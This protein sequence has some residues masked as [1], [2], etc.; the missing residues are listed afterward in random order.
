MSRKVDTV[1]LHQ[2]YQ[3]SLQYWPPHYLPYLKASKT[4]IQG[5]Y[6]IEVACLLSQLKIGVTSQAAAIAHYLQ[7]DPSTLDMSGIDPAQLNDMNF[8]LDKITLLDSLSLL[9]D[10]QARS[11]ETLRKMLLAMAQDIRAVVIIL[12]E[13]VVTMRHLK[14]VSEAEQKSIAKATIAIHAPLANRLGLARLKWELEDLSLRYAEPESYQKIARILD[15]KRD[16]REQYIVDVINEIKELLAKHNIKAEVSGRVKHLYSI[17]KKMENKGRSF[18]ELFDV[19]AVRILVNDVGDCYTALGLI[20]EKWSPIPKEFD[21]YIANPKLNGYQSLHTAVIGPKDKTLEV[22]IRTTAMHDYA[23]LGV[24]AHWRYKEGNKA[25]N[26]QNTLNWLRQILDDKTGHSEDNLSE[27][28]AANAN[29]TDKND[30][31]NDVL[32]QFRAEV[33]SDH[34]YV[35]TPKGQAIEL[36]A[37]ATPLDFAYQIHT[38]I[39]HR[40]RGAKINGKIVP[41]SHVLKN[42]D[43]VEVLT[44]KEPLPSRD[45]ISP[46]L[47]YLKSAKSRAKV[48]SWFKQQDQEKNLHAGKVILDRE[49]NR[50]HYH[51]S[52]EALL[53]IA[54]KL[55]VSNINDL[56]IGLGSGDITLNQ[57]IARL[58]NGEKP[59]GN[60]GILNQKP[61]SKQNTKSD[62]NGIHVRGV[63]NLLTSIASCCKP[64][65]PELIGGFITLSRGVSIHLANCSNFL[66]LLEQDPMR[67]IEVEWGE[68]TIFNASVD[69]LLQAYDR[70]DLLKDITATISN[71]RL[72]ITNL[73]MHPEDSGEMH[74]EFSVD[75]NHI[76]QLSR[77]L[78]RLTQLPNVLEARRR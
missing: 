33:F 76:D 47:G 10:A 50:L 14:N 59:D 36:I 48:R 67:R 24:A 71:E 70:P 46:H 49:F 35:I 21:D 56:Y 7:L 45:W 26:Q 74:F 57:L 78:D 63:G 31:D 8:L 32:D 41:L 39:G 43:V 29:I 34:V 16:N 12:A 17:W 19:R 9:I 55:N 28:M 27:N 58:P 13:Q 30:T 52:T 69:I 2:W 77:L 66:N 37:G 51:C 11:Q 68:D 62:S 72:K 73:Q 64:A 6:A 3:E 25:S 22:Q 18:D 15:E 20:H 53:K 65:P 44:T 40:C 42:G 4:H 38:N 23:E 1:S 61:K 5:E 75:V 54:N 60:I